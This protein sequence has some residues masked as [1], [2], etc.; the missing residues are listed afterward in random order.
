[1]AARTLRGSPKGLWLGR[2]LGAL[3]AFAPGVALACPYCA[4][5]AQGGTSTYVVIAAFVLLPW[6]LSWAIYRVIR[7]GEPTLSTEATPPVTANRSRRQ[8]S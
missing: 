3:V 2:I 5:R 7:S 6:L 8:L 1:M 4:G